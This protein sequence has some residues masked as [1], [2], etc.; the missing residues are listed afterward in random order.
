MTTGATASYTE[1]RRREDE[2]PEDLLALLIAGASTEPHRV[3]EI[4]IVP[5]GGATLGRGAGE[6]GLRITFVRQRPGRNEATPPLGGAGLSRDQIR[7]VLRADRL[8]VELT[9]RAPLTHLDTDVERCVLRV[10][11]AI[12]LRGQLTLVCVRRPVVLPR[13]AHFP[14][15]AMGAFGEVDRFGTLGESPSAWATRDRVAFAAQSNGHA[16][17]FGESGTGK[18]LAARAVHGLSARRAKTFIARNAATLPRGLIDAELF[19]SAKNYPNAGMQERLG[20]VGEADGGTFFLDEIA[21]LP[22]ELQS[23]LLRVLD[24]DGEYQRLGDASPRRSNFVLLGA[25]NREP[26]ALKH[27]LLARF[28]VRVQL[29]A[30]REHVDDLPLLVRHLMMRAAKKSPEIAE[31]FLADVDGVIHP[32]VNHRLLCALLDYGYPSNVRE[33]DSI[34]WQAMAASPSDT[35]MGSPALFQSLRPTP[36]PTTELTAA[37]IREE[38]AL[39]GN[40]MTQTA[41]SLGLPS[42]YSL[43]RWMKKLGV[44]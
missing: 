34:L 27:D 1:D 29:P 28:P 11:D 36:E 7:V 21:E 15:D 18:E 31:R 40:S 10:G 17:F 6:G 39:H 14:E 22:S 9:G 41:R 8:E 19:G 4:G 25:T 43:Y 13:L 35:L 37:R 42:R 26:D 23:H 38:L 2:S 5:S 12:T 24:A 30:L 20:L 32:R 44:D 3:G 16:L 33:L